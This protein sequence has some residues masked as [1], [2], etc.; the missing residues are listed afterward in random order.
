MHGIDQHEPLLDAALFD[1]RL[2]LLCDVEVGAPRL[3]LEP[4]LFA[5]GFHGRRSVGVH[6]AE[7]DTQDASRTPFPTPSI[8]LAAAG[9]YVRCPSRKRPRPYARPYLYDFDFQPIQLRL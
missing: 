7:L 4:E 1:R 8:N 9:I 3:R 6:S 5:I 2:N